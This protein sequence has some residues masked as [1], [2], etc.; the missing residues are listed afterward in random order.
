MVPRLLTRIYDGI[1][2]KISDAGFFGKKM[3]SWG[4]NSKVGQLERQGGKTDHNM[5]DKMVFKKTR[6]MLGNEVRFMITASAPVAKEVLNFLKCAFCCPIYE[7][8]GLTETT[9]PTSVTSA[10]DGHAGHVGG[11]LVN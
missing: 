1:Q 7:A 5:W 4:M 2:A 8:Y 3:F 9:G 11:P 10:H 6:E